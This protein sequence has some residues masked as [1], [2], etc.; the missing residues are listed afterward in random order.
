MTDSV[1]NIYESELANIMEIIP[2]VKAKLELWDRELTRDRFYDME[3]QQES[4]YSVYNTLVHIEEWLQYAGILL[5]E[6]PQYFPDKQ[7]IKRND[8]LLN[9]ELDSLHKYL[10]IAKNIDEFLA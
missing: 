3:S 6:L 8:K 2:D 1:Q 7:Y 9:R 5:S 10:K 4:F